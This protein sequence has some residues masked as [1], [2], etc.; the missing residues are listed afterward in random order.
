MSPH[1]APFVAADPLIFL[2]GQLAFDSQGRIIGD[3]AEQTQRC[4]ERCRGV[5]GELGLDLCDVVKAT[6]WLRHAD[7]FPAFNAAYAMAFGAHK[8]ARSTVVSNL[9][10]ADALVEIELIARRRDA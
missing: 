5:L 1:L 8:P 10:L 4:L 6:V 3:V 7:D 9:V 2:S